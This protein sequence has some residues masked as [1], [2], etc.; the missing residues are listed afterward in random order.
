MTDEKG[1]FNVKPIEYRRILIVE[2][3]DAL[4]GSLPEHFSGL[5]TVIA[6]ATLSEAVEA[7]KNNCFDIIL[8]DLILPDGSGLKLFEHTD[9]TPVVILSDL[10]SDSNLIE[11]FSAGAMDYIVKPASMELIEM[12]MGLRLLPA[13]ESVLLLHGLKL[14]LQNRTVSY[15]ER[16]LDLTPSEFNILAFLMQ[17]AGRFYTASDIYE[18]VWKLPH[19]NTT[20]TKAHLSN[21][22]KKMLAVSKECAGLIMTEFGKGYSFMGGVK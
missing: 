21:L 22:R 4:R 13:D 17:N 14:D 15:R 20:T 6:C 7:V 19:L 2:D 9:G 11:G 1:C 18:N 3:S 16:A 5:N 10:G 8:L 12:R